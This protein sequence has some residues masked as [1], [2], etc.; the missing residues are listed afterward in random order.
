MN[1]FRLTSITAIILVQAC[2]GD[3][4]RGQETRSP[5]IQKIKSAKTLSWT[6]TFYERNTSK[7]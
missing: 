2:A 1:L 6:V 4:S 3:G 5:A 7:E